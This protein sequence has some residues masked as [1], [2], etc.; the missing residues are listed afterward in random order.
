LTI[1]LL[2]AKLR[3]MK[4]KTW[5]N[6]ELGRTTR[7]AECFGVTRSAISQWHTNGV[8]KKH[9]R[10]VREITQAQVSIEEMLPESA[11]PRSLATGAPQGR[12]HA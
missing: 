12:A 9:M 4:L 3:S 2:K 11:A 8:P 6:D 5:L 1:G 7:L 10:Q